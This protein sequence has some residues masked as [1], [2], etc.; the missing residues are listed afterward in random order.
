MHSTMNQVHSTHPQ[1]L[2]HFSYM[3]MDSHSIDLPELEFAPYIMKVVPQVRAA[4]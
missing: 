2:V 3:G 1:T 4:S